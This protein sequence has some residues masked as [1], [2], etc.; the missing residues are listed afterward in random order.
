MLEVE[1]DE[2]SAG[3]P[4]LRSR[5]AA[6]ALESPCSAAGWIVAMARIQ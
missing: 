3:C 6:S 5:V 1:R 2:I 4:S